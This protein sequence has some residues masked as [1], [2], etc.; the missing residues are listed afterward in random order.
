A[1]AAVVEHDGLSAT[2]E[3]CVGYG[4]GG[5]TVAAGAVG[6]APGAAGGGGAPPPPPRNRGGEGEDTPAAPFQASP[7]IRP[8]PPPRRPPPAR[9]P[10]LPGRRP[11]PQGERSRVTPL[12][13]STPT[14]PILDLSP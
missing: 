6:A 9:R 8:R 10:V 4:G 3:H 1:L 7:H 5:G 2:L 12:I 11:P 14:R 13:A